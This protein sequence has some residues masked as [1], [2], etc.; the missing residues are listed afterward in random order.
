VLPAALTAD[1]GLYGATIAGLFR[2]GGKLSHDR[3][4]GYGAANLLVFCALWPA[5]MYGLA[6]HA[7]R[8][9]A[10]I[11]ALRRGTARGAER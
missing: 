1:D 11:S 8:Q 7:L 4:T 9:R 10:R 5:L 2:L 3:R 6:V